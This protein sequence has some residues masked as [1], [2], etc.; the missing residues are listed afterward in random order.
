M[1][2]RLW[3]YALSMLPCLAYCRGSSPTA[4]EAGYGISRNWLQRVG[5]EATAVQQYIPHSCCWRRPYTEHLLPVADYINSQR[6]GKAAYIHASAATAATYRYTPVT[7]GRLITLLHRWGWHRHSHLCCGRRLFRCNRAY[8]QLQHMLHA[9]NRMPTSLLF[10][11]R[12]SIYCCTRIYIPCMHP[13]Q[14][15]APKPKKPCIPGT[16]QQ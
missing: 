13:A 6:I 9:Q 12:L 8:R 11:R 16:A 14:Q 3:Q 4:V 15:Q 10:H 1:Y 7:R 2:T 5:E